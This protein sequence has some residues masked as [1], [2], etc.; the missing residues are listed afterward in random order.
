MNAIGPLKIV[1]DNGLYLSGFDNHMVDNDHLWCAEDAVKQKRDIE[2]RFLSL[3]DIKKGDLIFPEQEAKAMQQRGGALMLVLTPWANS[4]SQDDLFKNEDILAGKHYDV[5]RAFAEGAAG[6]GGVFRTLHNLLFESQIPVFVTWAPAPQ[7]FDKYPWGKNQAN[8]PDPE[9]YKRTFRYVHKVIDDYIVEKKGKSNLTWVYTAQAGP[10]AMAFDPGPSYRDWVSLTSFARNGESFAQTFEPS[11]RQIAAVDP[12]LPIMIGDYGISPTD[13][14]GKPVDRARIFEEGVALAA[15]GRYKI[16]AINYHNVNESGEAWAI[17]HRQEKNA[18][19]KAL[20]N[21]D[22]LFRSV[23]G[24]GLYEGTIKLADGT[25]LERGE[26]KPPEKPCSELEGNW[27]NWYW[28]TEV[29]NL[30]RSIGIKEDCVKGFLCNG[31]E[32]NRWHKLAAKRYLQMSNLQQHDAQARNE[33]IK[34]AEDHIKAGLNTID[35]NMI[36]PNWPPIDYIP[37]YFDLNME[38]AEIY[39]TYGSFIS[40]NPLQPTSDRICQELLS[41]DKG[42]YNSALRRAHNLGDE[43]IDGVVARTTLIQ[44]GNQLQV[45]SESS[46]LEAVK[47]FQQVI[48]WQKKE[49]NCGG[50][51]SC[52]VNWFPLFYKH[53]KG[54][55]DFTPGPEVQYVGALAQLGKAEALE[56]LSD[57]QPANKANLLNQAFDIYVEVMNWDLVGKERAFLQ[58][59][60]MNLALKSFVGVMQGC[61][62]DWDGSRD[63]NDPTNLERAA[64]KFEHALPWDK[65]NQYEDLKKSLGIP[66][67]DLGPLPAGQKSTQKWRMIINRL[68]YAPLTPPDQVRLIEIFDLMPDNLK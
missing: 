51:A 48:D 37:L 65:I 64:D 8:Q 43:S 55:F 62:A 38:L 46:L 41:K 21:Q 23:H 13:Q 1:A 60:F 36:Y 28:K 16:G 52:T 31:T 19:A 39:G 9:L 50:P 24:I 61:L 7:V 47:L 53:G 45:G 27:Y 59:G 4:G 14:A 66:G 15:S 2:V 42:V 17:T 6:E 68:R 18:F 40:A 44:A 33:A 26:V 58:N 5:L 12:Q 25:H 20:E 35:N 67:A 3:A 56:R 54:D 34:K 29:T 63:L 32:P 22:R 10:D 49:T 30:Q 57:L 11:L